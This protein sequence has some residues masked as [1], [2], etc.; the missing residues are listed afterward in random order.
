MPA[1]SLD[2]FVDAQD[3]VMESVRA[4]LKSGRKRTHWMWFVFPQIRGLGHSAM[5]ERYAISSREEAKSYV[6]HPLLGVRLRE[7]T[8]LVLAVEGQTVH[9]VFGSPDD[10]KFHSCMTLFAHA[11]PEEPLFR[12][13]LDRHFGGKEDPLTLARLAA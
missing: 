12:A 5:A 6:A 7:C 1:T 13:A 8:E 3:R 11:A 10:L 9:D 4:E 2:R